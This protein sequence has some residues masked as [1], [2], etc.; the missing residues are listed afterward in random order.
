MSKSELSANVSESA[1]IA[2]SGILDTEGLLAAAMLDLDGKVGLG[3]RAKAFRL[4]RRAPRR[5]GSA[6]VF[7]LRGPGI[8]KEISTGTSEQDEAEKFKARHILRL[9]GEAKGHRVPRS[10]KLALVVAHAAD[11]FEP[12]KG[13]TGAQWKRYDDMLFQLRMMLI[14]APNATLGDIDEQWCRDYAAWRRH[15]LEHFGGEPPVAFERRPVSN[16]QIHND[17]KSLQKAIDAYELKHQLPWTPTLVVPEKDKGRVR[18]LDASELRRILGAIRGRI[19]NAA[20]KRWLFEEIVDPDTGSVTTR[21]VLRDEAERRRRTETLWPLFLFGVTT[22]TRITALCG[23]RW[24]A[25]DQWG[26]VDLERGVIHR[27]GFA[28]DPEGGKPQMCTEIPQWLVKRLS[29]M[30]NDDVEIGAT[31]LVH[32]EEGSPYRSAPAKTWKAVI[33]D[34]GLG[35]DVT[36]HVMRHTCCTMLLAMGYSVSD[37]AQY[38]GMHPK[39]FERTYGH[40][41]GSGAARVAR[42]LAAKGG[43]KN[44]PDRH[45]EAHSSSSALAPRE[46][47]P[48]IRP[49]RGKSPITKSRIAAAMRG[50]HARRRAATH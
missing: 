48:L 3:R 33:A 20:T 34:A 13:A 1:L 15:E 43:L 41:T 12:D 24:S 26:W 14:F 5:A 7:Y 42:G 16:S 36:F 22:G 25:S 46:Q 35:S 31:H 19:W 21:F 49:R 4:K 27:K 10:V 32:K 45:G 44:M 40:P 6:G 8:K 39:T 30:R 47:A 11:R 18:W 23:I 9:V 17:F 38:V 37:A 28:V 50:V 29:R 2:H